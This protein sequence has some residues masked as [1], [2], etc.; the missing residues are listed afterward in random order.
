MIDFTEGADLAELHD[1][2]RAV[3]RDLLGTA[4]GGAPAVK[5][6]TP[7]DW[8]QLAAVG[9]LGLEV[10]EELGGAGAS[11]A[12]AAV[13]LT[14]LGRAAAR[15]SYLGTAVLGVGALLA[16]EPSAGRDELLRA[17]ATGAP[18]FAV[19]LATGDDEDIPFHLRADGRGGFTLRGEARFVPDLAEAERLLL[20]ARDPDGQP[21]VV[22]TEPGRPGLD[23]V[24]VPVLD[25]TRS[26]GDVSAAGAG[27][28]VSADQVARFR[29]DPWAAARGL[30]DRGVLA[31]ACD[32]LGAAEAMLDATVAYARV[33]E[34]FGRPIGSFQAV[35]H[36]CA[37]LFVAVSVGRELV[38][39]AARACAAGDQ[40]AGR[41]VAMAKSYVGGA[42]VEIAGKAMQLHGGIGYT[43]E[44]GIHVY[45]KRCVLGRALFGTPAAH[46]ARLAERFAGPRRG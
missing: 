16:L 10:P 12:E 18:R 19:G 35:Q 15:S 13:V 42:A 31:T 5:E 44:A 36:A 2:L 28:V 25:A 9:W 3:A 14:E 7:V 21:V 45:L 34:Q 22:L 32:S 26:L 8:E 37:D 11:L 23:V 40:D 20:L 38:A 43:W 27:A 6:A 4:A 24:D 30:R 1:E 39:A 17:A 33:R 41:A 46:R 29:G